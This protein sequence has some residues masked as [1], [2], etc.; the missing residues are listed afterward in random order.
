MR[1]RYGSCSSCGARII[2]LRTAAGKGMPC[3]PDTVPP[4]DLNFDAKLGHV[5]HFAMCK[6][7]DQHRKREEVAPAGPRAQQLALLPDLA[8]AR[9]ADG[10][11]GL[12]EAPADEWADLE[13]APA[14]PAK[15]MDEEKIARIGQLLDYWGIA[16]RD[17]RA[18]REAEGLGAPIETW[19]EATYHKIQALAVQTAMRRDEVAK[20]LHERKEA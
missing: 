5:S 7:R 3:E 18:I 19:D 11:P 20:Q 10:W 15:F 2:W 9:P 12:V 1:S 13:T 17:F 8:E 6:D 14:A 16:R 4:G